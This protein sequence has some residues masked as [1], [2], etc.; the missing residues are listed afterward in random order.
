VI[1]ESSGGLPY[2]RRSLRSLLERFPDRMTGLNRWDTA[3]LRYTRDVGP[4]SARIVAYTLGYES[5]GPDQVGDGYLFARLRRL[6][7]PALRHPLLTLSG[8][9]VRI[10]GTRVILT[11]AGLAVLAGRANFVALN[12]IDEWVGGIHLDSASGRVWFRRGATLVSRR[13]RP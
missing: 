8:N 5:D 2:L 11:D 4:A 3:L 1:S 6:G 10:G 13:V 7:D 12:G 9:R